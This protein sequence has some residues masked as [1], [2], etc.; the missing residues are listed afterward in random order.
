MPEKEVYTIDKGK[1]IKNLGD[2]S[3][4]RNWVMAR[5]RRRSRGED[6]KKL[7]LNWLDILFKLLTEQEVGKAY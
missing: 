5:R 2:E 3:K 4:G 1:V 7:K 6:L